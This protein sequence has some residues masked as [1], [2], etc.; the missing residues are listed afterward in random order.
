MLY[1]N[2]LQLLNVSIVSYFIYFIGVCVCTCPHTRHIGGSLLTML[3]PGIE[4]RLSG[5]TANAH[6]VE[7][8]AY[9]YRL[10]MFFV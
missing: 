1:S 9:S 6:L 5:I 3:F 8:L 10:F 7:P 4:L 2:H